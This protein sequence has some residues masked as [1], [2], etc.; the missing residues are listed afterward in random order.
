MLR[1]CTFYSN[2]LTRH[3]LGLAYAQHAFS[4]L[5]NEKTDD[6]IEFFQRAQDVGF[7]DRV[8][9]QGY[10]I[11]LDKAGRW[12][13]A[14]MALEGAMAL[15]AE[16]AAAPRASGRGRPDLQAVD[17]EFQSNG[18]MDGFRELSPEHHKYTIPFV[19]IAAPI[20]QVAA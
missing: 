15:P 10:A 7:T 14:E 20:Y 5:R 8:L 16:D 4:L 13:E 1:A 11:A 3:N 6:A 17:L 18:R 12:D 19:G 9:L 2:A